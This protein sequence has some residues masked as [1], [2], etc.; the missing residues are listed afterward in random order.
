MHF[1]IAAVGG[2]VRAFGGNGMVAP[3][4][5]CVFSWVWYFVERFVL[6]K[7]LD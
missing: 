4:K 1:R 6:R 5:S 3:D 7:W 2:S